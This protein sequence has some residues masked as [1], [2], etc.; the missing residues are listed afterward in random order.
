[1]LVQRSTF[2]TSKASTSRPTSRH[3]CVLA[4]LTS[5][6]GA[7]Q[8][9]GGAIALCIDQYEHRGQGRRRSCPKRAIID[10]IPTLIRP[11]F[12]NARHFN[13]G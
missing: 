2:N 13:A 7:I 6:D 3:H 8:S 5:R 9:R 4:L 1:M 10:G 12:P 11:Y